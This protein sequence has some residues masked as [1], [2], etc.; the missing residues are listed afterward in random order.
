MQDVFEVQDEI[1]RKIAEALRITLTPQE[2]AALAAKPTE[3][4]QAY[5]LYLRGKSYAR[6][7]TRQDLEFALQMF[8][9]AV[10]LDPG[11]RAGLR[12]DRQ[13]L[14]PA[15]T[16]NYGREPVWMERAE[17]AAEQARRARGR[18]ARRRR[19]PRPGCS[20]AARQ[21]RGGDRVVRAG[22]RAAS[23]TARAPTT[24]SAARCSRPAATRRSPTSPSAALEAAGEDYNVYVPIMNALGALGK[25]DARPQHPAA[26][27]R[28][29]SKRTCARCPRTRARGSC[30]PSTTP[31]T[32]RIDDAHARGEPGDAC[33][34]RTRRRCSTTRPAPSARSNRKAEALDALAKAWDAGFRDADWARRDPDLALLHGDPEFERLY[35]EKSAR[36]AETRGAEM[37]RSRWSAEPSRTTGSSA[38][39]AP[40]AWASST[41]PRTPQLG[42][43]VALK[44][45]PEE[46]ARD[47]PTLERFQREARAASA[48]N[49]PNICT[50]HAI[51]QHEGEHFIVMELL[52]GETLAR[53]ASAGS[54]ST[55]ERLLDV[56][57]PDRRRARG[58]ARQGHRPPRH[59]AGQHLRHAA[60]AGED[61]RFRAGQDRAPRRIDRR[62]RSRD[63]SATARGRAT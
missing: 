4:L 18:T 7:L 32:G 16:T 39:W 45:L 51:E 50:V 46:L 61:P 11:V 43:R 17:A 29:R 35:P 31:T 25:N 6:R 21:L 27:H 10:A 2:Q 53:R 24:C 23:R 3:N 48:L 38:R 55:I 37:L 58:G 26:A 41:R 14:R 19:S 36:G 33:C 44:F 63:R 5:D 54:R 30:S 34:A 22:D 47:P 56:G 1:A 8:E 57:D 52:E 49:H 9:N 59:Q 15:S 13:R 28:R 12:R 40:A 62:E 42:R 60:R 20:Y